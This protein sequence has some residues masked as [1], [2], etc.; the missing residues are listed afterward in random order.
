MGTY[1][2]VQCLC[3]MENSLK[4]FATVTALTVSFLSAGAFADNTVGMQSHKASA[5]VTIVYKN[6]VGSTK[7]EI[8]DR[9]C[10]LNSCVEA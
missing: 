1:F 7:A 9:I 3:L 8:T 4:T 5:N 10:K 2:Q 6:L